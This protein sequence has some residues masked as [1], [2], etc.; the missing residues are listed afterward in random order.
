[1]MNNVNIYRLTGNTLAQN[2][3]SLNNSHRVDQSLSLVGFGL[4]YLG[5]RPY[6]IQLPCR[7]ETVKWGRG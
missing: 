5:L 3:T 2:K 1:M 6:E 7:N 4:S